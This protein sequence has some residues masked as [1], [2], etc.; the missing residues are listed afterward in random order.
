[1]ATNFFYQAKKYLRQHNS[2]SFAT[3][4]E[5]FKTVRLI[6]RQLLELGFKGLELKSL[7]PKHI[8]AL[9]QRWQAEQLSP[10]TI[11]NRMSHVRWLA[12][13]IGK[14]GIVPT[15][16]TA[17]GIEKR[18]YVFNENKSRQLSMAQF[19]SIP[20]QHVRMSLRLQ[21]AFGLRR[22]EAMKIQPNLA[23]LGSFLRLSASWCKGGRERE[24]PILSKHQRELLNEARALANGGSLIPADK[25]YAEQVKRYENVCIKIGLD[26]AH[27]LRHHYAQ[28]R[29]LALT[30]FDCPAVSGVDLRKMSENHRLIDEV[31]RKSITKELG[32]NRLQVTNV[33]LS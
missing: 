26:R 28:Q 30:G 7:K 19:K 15:S 10:G 33:Y 8:N 17:L 6:D 22:E 5:R 24:I 3:K 2:S 20:D 1:M 11:K 13:K 18:Q 9:L 31:A 25:S 12:E 23:D 16:N 29:Y 27:G 4:S 21:L 32:H 14:K